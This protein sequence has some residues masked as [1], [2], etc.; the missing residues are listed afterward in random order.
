MSLPPRSVSRLGEPRIPL[1]FKVV[2]DPDDLP[3]IST[4]D[5][6]AN[7]TVPPIQVSNELQQNMKEYMECIDH[8]KKL[9]TRMKKALDD[10]ASV[11]QNGVEFE[12]EIS[13]AAVVDMQILLFNTRNMLKNKNKY[14]VTYRLEVNEMQSTSR[15]L[16]NQVVEQQSAKAASFDAS[17]SPS[18]AGGGGGEGRSSAYSDSRSWASPS[19]TSNENDRARK[20]L[21]T[22]PG[23]FS[24]GGEE[25]SELA[26]LRRRVQETLNHKP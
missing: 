19:R 3:G 7:R 14:M 1:S 26:L 8:E 12:K 9:A 22:R 18:R 5:F 25:E 24:A 6:K 2:V 17:R 10:V 23:Y 21:D 13:G 11:V 16:R 20:G 4:H 15:Q